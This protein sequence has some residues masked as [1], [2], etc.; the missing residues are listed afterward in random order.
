M[1]SENQQQNSQPETP[2]ELKEKGNQAVRQ[3]RYSEAVLH[4]S[5]AIKL[6][7][8]D[9]ILYSNRSFAFLKLKQ[10]YY[11]NEDAEKAIQLK[12]DWAKAHFRKAEVHLAA[13]QY[14]VSLLSYGRALQLQPN[15]SILNAAKH[16]ASLSTKQAYYESRVPWAGAGIGIVLGVIIV[17]SDQLT[18]SP[19]LKHPILMLLLI[20]ALAGVCYGIARLFRYYSKLQNRGLL[21]PPIDIL[22]SFKQ[23]SEDIEGNNVD[24]TPI[25]NRYSKAQARQRF[26]KG[27]AK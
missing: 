11:A 26:R 2:D 21:D 23:T 27:L 5:F 10:L 25:R 3:E 24:S 16:C 6:S 8:N 22:D 9:P 1:E 15:E 17:V 14:D 7:P 20:M 12:P 18:K 4:Y 13:A 19:A